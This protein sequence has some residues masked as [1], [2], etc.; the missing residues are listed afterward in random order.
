ME[1]YNFLL[2]VAIIILSTKFMGG[3][4]E[5]VNMPQVV[6]ALVA[7]VILGPSVLG[8][9]ESTNFLAETAEIGVILLMFMAGLVQISTKLR[10]TACLCSA[11]L[12][13]V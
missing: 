11:S 4:S 6:G 2:A 1:N 7:G 9:V 10:R 13:Q 3:L 5:K 8:I 12:W